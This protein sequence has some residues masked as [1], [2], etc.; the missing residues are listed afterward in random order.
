MLGLSLRT[1]SLARTPILRYSV[2]AMITRRQS[3]D[4]MLW[5][6]IGVALPTTGCATCPSPSPFLTTPLPQ[7]QPCQGPA[8]ALRE[9][10]VALLR[11]TT[12]PLPIVLRDADQTE[13]LRRHA[14]IVSPSDRDHLGDLERRLRETLADSGN[15]VG[16][17]A[18]QIGI[19]VRAIVVMLDARG[20]NPHVDC[21][22]NP[23]IIERSDDLTLDYEG[24]LSI[25][26]VCGLVKRNRRI[27]V[28]HGLFGSRDRLVAEQF[29]ARIFQ[30]EIDHLDGVLYVDRV[31]GQTHPK[32]KLKELRE[33]LRAQ[34]PAVACTPRFGGRHRDEILL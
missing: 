6:A 16:L 28:E 1:P 12:R 22:L 18:P 4:R 30:H 29:D 32:D 31:Q 34:Q 8:A 15:G 27:V 9:E 26:D 14:R 3:L 19:G 17:A 5:A 7:P 10:D 33:Q 13:I 20:N 24:C 2:F 23:R 21:F 11:S 25:P